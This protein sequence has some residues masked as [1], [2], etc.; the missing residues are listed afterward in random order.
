MLQFQVAAPGF[1]QHLHGGNEEAVGLGEQGDGLMEFDLHIW[2]RRAFRIK[3][4]AV[5]GVK[6]LVSRNH[7][8]V[9]KRTT[10]KNPLIPFQ[11]KTVLS[12]TIR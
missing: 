3:G 6:V 10:R 11:P 1:G 7:A 2:C 8:P 5:I 4:R 12:I 9:I